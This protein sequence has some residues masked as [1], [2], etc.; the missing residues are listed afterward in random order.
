MRYSFIFL[1]LGCD[2]LMILCVPARKKRIIV[3]VIPLL[4]SV[5]SL[6]IIPSLVDN[7]QLRA[8]KIERSLRL[9]YGYKPLTEWQICD[10]ILLFR[11]QCSLTK[12]SFMFIL[13]TFY[14]YCCLFFITQL[15]AFCTICCKISSEWFRHFDTKFKRSN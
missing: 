8:L 1:L 14:S 12:L 3:Y 4:M 11:N 15:I 2:L 13:L 7:K 9:V 5:T 10:L 6:L